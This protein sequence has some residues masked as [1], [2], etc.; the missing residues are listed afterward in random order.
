MVS[1]AS[2]WMMFY[3]DVLR[4][5]AL[6]VPTIDQGVTRQSRYRCLRNASIMHDLEVSGPWV[7]ERP[8][9]GAIP[10][11]HK[12]I[13]Q[14]PLTTQTLKNCPL[15]SY[16]S[17]HLLHRMDTGRADVWLKIASLA[18]YAQPGR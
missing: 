13:L 9:L 10:E 1:V 17:L 3:T 18:G 12:S 8:P 15:V 16:P 11:R 7:S 5:V 2:I 14:G 6:A 4:L